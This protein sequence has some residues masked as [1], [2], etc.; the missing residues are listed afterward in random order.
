MAQ[1]PPE[2]TIRQRARRRHVDPDAAI[3]VARGEG[4]LQNRE[5]DIGDLAGGGSYGPFQLYAQGAL[6]QQ[7]RGNP[8]AADQWAWS[9]EGID[10]AISKMAESGAAGL[11]G[12]DA[13]NAIVRK[14]ERPAKPDASVAA[15]LGRLGTGGGQ[16]SGGMGL[17]GETS[18][19]MPAPGA[20]PGDNRRELALQLLQSRR[21]GGDR[22]DL[23]SQF[24]Q[25]LPSQPPAQ[26]APPSPGAPPGGRATSSPG[27]GRTLP[28][29]LHSLGLDDAITGGERSVEHNREV[30][31]SP[32]SYH[33]AGDNVDAFDLNPSDSDIPKLL[34]LARAH[35]DQ[36]R[37]VYGPADWHV[38][39][40]KLVRGRFP[41]HDDHWHVAR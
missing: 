40:G 31:G 1:Q 41:D 24:S 12:A 32:T 13:V 18:T 17:G 36:F 2:Y 27:G 9:P 25:R 10:Y 8:Q 35:P 22:R 15:A 21:S 14:F 39:N 20:P 23:L 30:G 11:T 29:L 3:A 38:K 4:G 7:Y 37:E 33:L 28:A 5:D 34:Q 6:P 19:A 16:H 26:A